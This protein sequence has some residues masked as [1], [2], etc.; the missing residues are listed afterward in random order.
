MSKFLIA[1]FVFVSAF[2]VACAPR[3]VAPV[4]VAPPAPPIVDL[5]PWEG[6]I[7]ITVNGG[8]SVNSHQAEHA[9]MEELVLA[10]LA[11]SSVATS[12]GCLRLSGTATAGQALH[13]I[14]QISF[15]EGGTAKQREE[16]I[17]L[18]SSLRP[19]E[20]AYRAENERAAPPVTFSESADN[21]SDNSVASG[22]EEELQPSDMP[23]PASPHEE[24]E[25]EPS[26]EDLGSEEI[27]TAS[28]DHVA[29]DPQSIPMDFTLE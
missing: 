24:I 21:G 28:M 27:V 29:N 26:D 9:F 23:P 5:E 10:M 8:M 1:C 22:A 7:R 14:M 15:P 13:A 20:G 18:L 4:T 16:V 19:R 2:F 12:V 17:E 6:E 3:A 11:S 25:L